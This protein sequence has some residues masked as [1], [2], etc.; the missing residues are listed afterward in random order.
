MGGFHVSKKLV[1]VVTSNC[2]AVGLGLSF[3]P[4]V[5]LSKLHYHTRI[6]VEFTWLHYGGWEKKKKQSDCWALIK[7]WRLPFM[8]HDSP[9]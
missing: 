7:R 8:I 9:N 1:L 5:I 6:T 3:Q 4:K 2:W